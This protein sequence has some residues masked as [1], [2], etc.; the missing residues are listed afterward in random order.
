[1]AAARRVGQPVEFVS[2]TKPV[3]ISWPDASRGGPE[4]PPVAAARRVG[5]P[6]EFVSCTKPV[7][8]TYPLGVDRGLVNME[9]GAV[10][11]AQPG[12]WGSTP[13]PGSPR[14]RSQVWPHDVCFTSQ[15]SMDTLPPDVQRA[16]AAETGVDL[17]MAGVEVRRI[18]MP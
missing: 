16:F 12:A 1:V 11:G 8:T 17:E 7:V 6:V 9:P 14:R 2:C 4:A 3:V 10:G 13:D 18:I 5:Q 15:T